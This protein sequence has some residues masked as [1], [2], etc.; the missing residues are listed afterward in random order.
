MKVFLMKRY[1]LFA[2][3]VYYPDGGWSDFQGSFD[4]VKDATDYAL[5]NLEPYEKEDVG[6][7]N[8]YHVIDAFDWTTVEKI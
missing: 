6:R 1:F 5:S 2:G 3:S 4:S 8:W 7:F